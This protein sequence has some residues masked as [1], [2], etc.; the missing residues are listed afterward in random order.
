MNVMRLILILSI[1]YIN[2]QVLLK[3]FK[4]AFESYTKC[5]SLPEG[6]I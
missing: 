4:S 5:F 3:L 1:N 6:D 2:L